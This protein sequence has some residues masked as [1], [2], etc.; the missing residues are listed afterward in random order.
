VIGSK[1]FAYVSQDF[2]ALLANAVSF[3]VLFE[4]DG[5]F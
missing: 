5:D 4:V 2:R 3:L 1:A